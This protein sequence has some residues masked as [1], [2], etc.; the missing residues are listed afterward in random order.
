MAKGDIKKGGNVDD[1]EVIMNSAEVDQ[2]KVGDAVVLIGNYECGLSQDV[3][4]P[5]FGQVTKINLGNGDIDVRY[6]GLCVFTYTGPTPPIV[7]GRLGVEISSAIAGHVQRPNVN[8]GKGL[9]VSVDT[10]AKTV[11]VLL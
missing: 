4:K 9:V 7:N 11:D 1:F 8:A 2:M 6:R 10:E 3:G 5:I